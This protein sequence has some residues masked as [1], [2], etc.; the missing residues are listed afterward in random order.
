M[1]Y[2]L[3]IFLL[4]V[5]LGMLSCRQNPSNEGESNTSGNADTST[6]SRDIVARDTHNCK[7]EGEMLDGNSFWAR[8]QEVLVAIVADSTTY[9]ADLEA[10]GHRILEVYNTNDCSLIQREVLPIDESPDFPYYISDITYNNVTHLVG[11]RGTTSI[12]LYDVANKKLLPKLMPQFASKRPSIDAQSGMVQRLEVWENYLVGFAQ[13]YG[14]FVYNLSNPQS[15]Q[16]VMPYGEYKI[17]DGDYGSLFLLPADQD[18]KEQG[19][20]P[21]YDRETGEFQVNPLFEQPRDVATQQVQKSARNNRYLV[22]RDANNK[23]IAVDLQAHQ[24]INLPADV[25]SQAT[26]QVLDWVKKNR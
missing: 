24:Q 8:D 6:M 21:S 23:A 15:P 2:A 3:P 14:A 19:I 4:I 22:M 13:D 5:T 16:A 1:K 20:I 7:I 12:Y 10:P 25:A 18:G 9:S 26:Q 17:Q 11:I